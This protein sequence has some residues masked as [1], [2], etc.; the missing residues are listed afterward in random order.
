MTALTLADFITE[1]GQVDYLPA[2]FVARLTLSDFDQM[3]GQAR[4]EHLNRLDECELARTS[5][6]D[7]QRVRR[8]LRPSTHRLAVFHFVLNYFGQHL[9]QFSERIGNAPR[10]F[11]CTHEF[12]HS[13]VGETPKANGSGLGASDVSGLEPAG[14][15]SA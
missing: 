5:G 1:D 4:T 2:A 10:S 11:K 3:L 13:S 14:G 6:N 9:I 15:E 8:H 12:P 7:G